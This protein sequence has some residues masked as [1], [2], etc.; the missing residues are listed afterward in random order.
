[1]PNYRVKKTDYVD[2]TNRISLSLSAWVPVFTIGLFSA[3]GILQ[4]NEK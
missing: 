2:Q 3:I 4:I 1:M